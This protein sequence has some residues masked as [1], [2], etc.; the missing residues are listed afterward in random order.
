MGPQCTEENWG[1]DVGEN[2]PNSEARLGCGEAGLQCG[3]RVI[4]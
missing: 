3:R 4:E 2:M 1:P